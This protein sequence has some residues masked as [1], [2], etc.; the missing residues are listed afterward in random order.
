[1]LVIIFKKTDYGAEILYIKSKYFTTVD[2]NR[3][4]NEKL[5]LIIRQKRSF[6]KSDIADLVKN[7]ELYK[8]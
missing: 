1:M 2:Y 8:K 6:N 7:T 4:I 5:D 3:L